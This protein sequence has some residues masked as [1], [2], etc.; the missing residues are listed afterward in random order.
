MPSWGLLVLIISD[1]TT[2]DHKLKA[3][4]IPYLTASADQN[5]GGTLA[6]LSDQSFRRL[7]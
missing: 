6:R 5:S 4:P 1:S 3:Y 2:N 7:S